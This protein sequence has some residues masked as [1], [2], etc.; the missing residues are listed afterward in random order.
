MSD[1]NEPRA[2]CWYN[3]KKDGK[4]LL[5]ALVIILSIVITFA[6]IIVVPYYVGETVWPYADK[7]PASAIWIIGA[8]ITVMA[9]AVLYYSACALKE[10]YEGL[11]W[12]RDRYYPTPSKC[13]D[14]EAKDKAKAPEETESESEQA[15]RKTAEG[16]ELEQ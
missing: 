1:E 8:F 14:D 13:L 6:I 12:A 7:E 10:I 9:C 15:K 4:V 16:V 5:E 2:F 11:L 3:I